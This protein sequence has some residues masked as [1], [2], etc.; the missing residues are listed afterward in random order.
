[1]SEWLSSQS[2]EARSVGRR[3]LRRNRKW[4]GCRSRNCTHEAKLI[5]EH[6][7][8]RR[9]INT[10]DWKRHM[11]VAV[12]HAGMA[13][14]RRGGVTLHAVSSS[15]IRV[16]K[17]RSL[18]ADPSLGS[19]GSSH[20]LARVQAVAGCRIFV[21]RVRILTEDPSPPRLGSSSRCSAFVLKMP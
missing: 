1:M 8:S 12:E 4:S 16:R 18:S 19:D 11:R 13:G 15:L 5:Q 17:T 6:A 3:S 21:R 20:Y 2:L 14:P 9:D 10:S 7:A